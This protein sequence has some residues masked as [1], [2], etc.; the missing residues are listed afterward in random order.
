MTFVK[1][2][3]QDSTQTPID[4]AL[5]SPLE[6]AVERVKL[7][8]YFF[9]QVVSSFFSF[10]WSSLYWQC[11]NTEHLKQTPAFFFTSPPLLE[12]SDTFSESMAELVG[13]YQDSNPEKGSIKAINRELSRGCCYAE[14]LQLVRL[15]KEKGGPLSAH[16][17]TL[18]HHGPAITQLEIL[19]VFRPHFELNN[20]KDLIQKMQLLQP[21]GCTEQTTHESTVA[22]SLKND[23]KNFEGLIVTRLYNNSEAHAL[24]FSIDHTNS[25]YGFYNP[26]CLGGYYEYSSLDAFVEAVTEFNACHDNY[27]NWQLSFYPTPSM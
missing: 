25:H 27:S 13:A 15:V 9:F 8:I 19:E 18:D 4:A 21:E 10:Q 1:D 7:A 5:G 17:S 16:I 14:A 24:L 20:K 6:Q 12:E 26:T 22:P 11:K 2:I 3:R 23:L